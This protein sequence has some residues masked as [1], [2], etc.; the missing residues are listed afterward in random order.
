MESIT[1]RVRRKDEE[2]AIVVASPKRKQAMRLAVI[3]EATDGEVATALAELRRAARTMT[4]GELRGALS[5][6]S[7][8]GLFFRDLVGADVDR[9]LEALAREALS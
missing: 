9:E 6:L 4:W 1:V 3:P 8:I 5:Y 2:R 7:L